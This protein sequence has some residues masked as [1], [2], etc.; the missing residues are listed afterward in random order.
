MRPSSCNSATSWARAHRGRRDRDARHTCCTR[1]RSARGI[2]AVKPISN[3]VHLY[4]LRERGPASA[5]L[6]F[7]CGI[8]EQ[9]VAAKAGILSR[10]EQAAY[11]RAEGAPCPCVTGWAILLRPKPLAPLRIGLDH[12]AIRL[13]IAVLGKFQDVGPFEHACIVAVDRTERVVDAR[14]NGDVALLASG[15]IDVAGPSMRL[16]EPIV[17]IFNRKEIPKLDV[18]TDGSPPAFQ[19]VSKP[20]LKRPLG[21]SVERRADSPDYWKDGENAK[22]NGRLEGNFTRAPGRWPMHTPG[23]QNRSA[24]LGALGAWQSNS[25]IERISGKWLHIR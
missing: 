1:S 14:P 24:H 4:W 23:T 5:R 17:F 12:L 6:E 2:A 19:A 11:V 20:Y 15:S 9:S 22:R 21:V 25:L 18:R 3:D 16:Y 10:P 13:G 7:L 8:E